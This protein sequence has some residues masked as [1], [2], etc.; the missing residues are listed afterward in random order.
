MCRSWSTTINWPELRSYTW[1][2]IHNNLG[3]IHIMLRNNHQEICTRYLIRHFVV[4][5]VLAC[6][7]LQFKR[8]VVRKFCSLGHFVAWD[9]FKLTVV[10]YEF[11]T[12]CILGCYVDGTFCLRTF[13]NWYVLSLNVC[14]C[15]SI[16]VW[17]SLFVRA[18]LLGRFATRCLASLTH[19]LTVSFF[20][21]SIPI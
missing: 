21:I 9:I 13:Y 15:T 17:R 1:R 7:V 14:R 20:S 16:T 2:I 18:T 4:R 8:F 12:F 3:S 6:D 19:T 5:R 10:R 11:G